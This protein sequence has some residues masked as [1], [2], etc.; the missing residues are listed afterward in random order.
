MPEAL[1]AAVLM[2]REAKRRRTLAELEADYI[3][4]TLEATGGNKTE[5]ARLLKTDFKTLHGK[6]KK[7]GVQA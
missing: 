2:K 4:E 3:R 1:R 6:M 5:A 7:L